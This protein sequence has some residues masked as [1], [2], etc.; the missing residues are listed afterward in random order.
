MSDRYVLGRAKGSAGSCM[1][2]NLEPETLA[3]AQSSVRW[4]GRGFG[5]TEY[6]WHICT[7]VNGVFLNAAG[8]PMMVHRS[9][10]TAEAWDRFCAAYGA[11]LI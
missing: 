8:D 7:L 3:K 2:L 11:S 9:P 10:Y 5:E 4:Q 6:E 1:V